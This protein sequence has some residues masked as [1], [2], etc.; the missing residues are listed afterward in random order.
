[1]R[2]TVLSRLLIP[3]TSA[4]RERLQIGLATLAQ[5]DP[6]FVFTRM[7]GSDSIEL[8]GMGELH[9]QTIVDRL[10][11]DFGANLRMGPLR[12]VLKTVTLEPVMRVEVTTPAAHL[13]DVTRGIADR[14]GRM[15]STEQH[16]ATNVVVFHAPM[17]ALL[18]FAGDLRRQTDGRG[19]FQMRFERYDELPTGAEP[20]E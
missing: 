13:L 6:A 2:P 14:Q 5:D 17:R 18:G 3:Q 16:G 7:A 9:L 19:A 8:A 1:V 4:D 12:V 15:L 11:S 20:A 10:V